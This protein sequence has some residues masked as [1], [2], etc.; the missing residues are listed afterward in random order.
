MLDQSVFAKAWAMLK[1]RFGATLSE[2]QTKAYFRYLSDRIE[3]EEFRE[4][5]AMIWATNRFFP[6]P[7]DFLVIG[8]SKEWGKLQT[9]LD[10]FNPP[11]QTNQEA[12]QALGPL[13][14]KLVSDLGGFPSL[15][16]ALQKDP[17]RLRDQ[18]SRNYEHA[19]TVES[20]R[21]P[22]E[23]QG[24]EVTPTSRQIVSEVMGQLPP[25]TDR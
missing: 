12:I 25:A 19:A 16:A 17:I 24:P 9:A 10:G 20:G 22:K 6:R 8:A 4:A 5:A 2:E 18:F 1:E 3:T 21:R 23:L 7:V 11:H 13:T 15:K 14:R